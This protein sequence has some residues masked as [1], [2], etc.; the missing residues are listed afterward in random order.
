M[1]G[2]F[3]GGEGD[4]GKYGRDVEDGAGH[5]LAAVTVADD[6]GLGLRVG[7]G[8]V[9]LVALAA[10]FH[11]C[12]VE[13]LYVQGWLVIARARSYEFGAFCL[14]LLFSS[15][16]TDSSVVTD[17]TSSRLSIEVFIYC[18]I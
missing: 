16:S 4:V 15:R 3:G 14:E 5:N 17:G 9:D 8:E 18:F 6:Y 10:S 11:V 1:R 2:C 7:D 12:V 13:A